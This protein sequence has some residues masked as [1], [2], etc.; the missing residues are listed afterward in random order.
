[1]KAT[2]DQAEKQVRAIKGLKYNTQRLTIR[3]VIPEDIL[4]QEGKNKRNKTN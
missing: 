2:T 1:M 4:S 3:I